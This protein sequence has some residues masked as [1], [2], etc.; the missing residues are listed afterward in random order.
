MKPVDNVA[1]PQGLR[2]NALPLNKNPFNGL[3]RIDEIA[4]QRDF[5]DAGKAACHEAGHNDDPN[6]ELGAARSCTLPWLPRV[7]VA[8]ALTISPTIHAFSS[9]SH[10]RFVLIDISSFVELPIFRGK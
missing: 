4:A 1:I 9:H 3:I 2:D 8:K 7:R 6:H 10:N 5:A